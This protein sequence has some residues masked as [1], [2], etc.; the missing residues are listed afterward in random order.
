MTEPQTGLTIGYVPR[1]TAGGEARPDESTLAIVRYGLPAPSLLPEALTVSIPM[2]Q[3][4]DPTD[5][6][7]RVAEPVTRGEAGGVRFARTGALLF[8][9]VTLP[10]A[11]DEPLDERSRTAYRSI[12]SFVQ[13]Q[14]YPHLIRMWNFLPRIN[15]EEGGLERYQRF[16]VGRAEGFAAV[17]GDEEACRF[18]S[19]TAVGSMADDSLS[20]HFIAAVREPR[21]VE[22]PRQVSAYLYPRRYGPKSPS[23]ARATVPADGGPS[24]VYIAGTASI[25]GSESRHEG[26]LAAQYRETMANIDALVERTR[27][28]EKAG[29]YKIYIR[30]ETDY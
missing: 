11:P 18:P 9:A 2:P 26:N 16:C 13:G 27:G 12:L 1:T 6:V 28:D 22:N 19:A 8:G 4:G 7:W 15:A 29:L 25:A 30:R 5:E 17:F 23:F 14:G 10:Q 21:H 24:R 3:F 20:I